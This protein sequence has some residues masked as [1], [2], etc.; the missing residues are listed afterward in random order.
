MGP[1]TTILKSPLKFLLG[2]FAICICLS[3]Q[4]QNTKGDKPAPPPTPPA[5]EKKGLFG[6]KNRIKGSG[7]RARNVFPQ[8]GPFVH[9]P[10]KKPK[11]EKPNTLKYPGYSATEKPSKRRE[12]PSSVRLPGY[13]PSQS[14][15][16]RDKAWTKG[17][18]SG[19]RIRTNTR[20]A[21]VRNNIY[22]QRGPYV[23][24]PSRKPKK[25][26]PSTVRLPSSVKTVRRPKGRDQAWS[27]G[28]ISGHK[29]PSRKPSQQRVRVIPQ[30]GPYV[31][32]GP[33]PKPKLRNEP[34]SKSRRLSISKAVA[35]GRSMGIRGAGFKSITSQFITRGKKNV[36]WGKF[37]KKEKAVTTDIAGRKVRKLNYH[38][39]RVGLVGR[40]TLP[41]FR[42][43]PK[44]VRRAPSTPLGGYKSATRTGRPWSGDISGSKIRR[45]KAK[46]NN[47]V[48][49]E[50]VFPRKLSVTG[51]IKRGGRKGGVP[52]AATPKKRKIYTSP[53]PGKAPGAGAKAFSMF[54]K[55][56]KP[57]KRLTGAGGSLSGKTWNNKNQPLQG[58]APGLGAKEYWSFAK[59]AKPGKRISGA[60]GSLSGRLWNNNNQ[61]V[62]G[63]AP[64]LGAQGYAKFSKQAKGQRRPSGFGGSASGRH[65]NNKNKPIMGKS[66][67]LS[68]YFAAQF[69]GRTKTRRPPKGGGSVSGKLWNNNN[70]PI[71]VNKAGKGTI[72]AAQFK[73]RIR[74][75][76]GKAFSTLG[77]DYTGSKKTR[78]PPKGGGSV[79][80]KLWNNNNQPID[81]NGASKDTQRATKFAG[82]I[83][84][85]QPPKGGGSI[86]GKIWNNNNRPIDVNEAGKGTV[87]ASKFQGKIKYQKPPETAG[88]PAT[89]KGKIKGAISGPEL[90]QLGL[91]YTGDYKRRDKGKI[92]NKHVSVFAKVFK[93]EQTLPATHIRK[94]EKVANYTMRGKRYIFSKYVQNPNAHKESLKKDRVPNG[95]R[96]NVPIL[97][98]TRRSVNAGH[99]NHVMKQNWD[100][101]HNPN[102][103]KSAL[104]VREPSKANA[105]IGDLQVNVKMKKIYH[106]EL[107]PDA[108]FAHSY[109]NNVKEERTLFMNIRLT[110]AKLFKKGDNQPRGLKQKPT[111]PRYD[112]N[113]KGL[114]YD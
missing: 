110:W 101:V 1:K 96:L 9:N 7:R 18:A 60:G 107:H 111:R 38:S 73:G 25:E 66:L 41:F 109:R 3:T 74:G 97:N 78:R 72:D 44:S 34:L 99:Y 48:A 46:R 21:R 87:R 57:G 24:N 37:R 92:D 19:K 84:T 94:D 58:K 49:G 4:A 65:W 88:P 23:H 11:K 12:K 67:S 114:W 71:D 70:Q 85:K 42:R 43:S 54:S 83:K 20:S 82:N 31:S 2:L 32:R 104:K 64:G 100:Y 36:Y 52:I 90:S 108:K 51:K 59:H 62:Q 6:E 93:K 39:P 63:K 50:F 10:S 30:S 47:E 40:D 95:L 79:S 106:G 5:K 89:F 55:Q 22:P 68:S 61:P 35:Q 76:Y 33:R 80:G 45:N 28:D 86:S 105:R 53:L 112:P 14:P 13:H 16:G 26:K 98:Q 91:D 77:L 17:N 27:K 102:S 75:V 103:N 8:S 69:S 29:L 15:S 113:E 81:V 56:A